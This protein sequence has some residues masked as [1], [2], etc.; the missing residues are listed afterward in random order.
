MSRSNKHKIMDGRYVFFNL[1]IHLQGERTDI[2][3]IVVEGESTGTMVGGEEVGNEG[4]CNWI[5]SSLEGRGE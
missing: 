4:V 5:T 3:S 2:H 1:I